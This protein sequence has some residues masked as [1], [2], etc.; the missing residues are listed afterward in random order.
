MIAVG[1]RKGLRVRDLLE[2]G[3]MARSTLLEVRVKRGKGPT[4]TMQPG[5]AIAFLRLNPG[6]KAHV[7]FSHSFVPD[8]SGMPVV[9]SETGT[10]T[11]EAMVAGV[12]DTIYLQED[13]R[14]AHA[15]VALPGGPVADGRGGWLLARPVSVMIA[16]FLIGSALCI[17]AALPLLIASP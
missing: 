1:S 5:E 15:L 16:F 10:L 6:D 12:L 13:T 4:R 2:R 3:R 11:C 8:R 14:L 9:V 7:G 17:G